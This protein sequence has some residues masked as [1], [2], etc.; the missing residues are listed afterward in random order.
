MLLESLRLWQPRFIPGK[1]ETQATGCLSQLF[2]IT[3]VITEQVFSLNIN[4]L[5]LNF[6]IGQSA[7]V[8]AGNML[9]RTTLVP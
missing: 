8:L 4:C 3:S 6:M 9:H 5:S 7:L 2:L 1:I